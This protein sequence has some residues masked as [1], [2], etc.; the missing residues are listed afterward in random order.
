VN[1]ILFALAGEVCVLTSELLKGS[2]FLE[3]FC[4]ASCSLLLVDL[5]F[6]FQNKDDLHNVMN[7]CLHFVVYVFFCHH[8]VSCQVCCKSKS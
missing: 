8:S 1:E 7:K 3:L 6:Q 4:V 2:M 5:M